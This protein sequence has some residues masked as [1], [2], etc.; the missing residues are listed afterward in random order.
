MVSNQGDF[1]VGGGEGGGERDDSISGTFLWKSQSINSSLKGG[2][3]AEEETKQSQPHLHN[4]S[5]ARCLAGV[6]IRFS[7]EQGHFPSV[8]RGDE[9]PTLKW[10]KDTECRI[11]K[12][13]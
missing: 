12:A 1:L 2:G 8:R 3:G 11:L 5:R 13:F 7:G 9:N 6:V 10:K 4:R